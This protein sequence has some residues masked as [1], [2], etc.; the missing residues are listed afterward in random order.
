MK[1]SSH[2]VVPF[3]EFSCAVCGAQLDPTH[4]E[5][6]PE[7]TRCAFCGAVQPV[8]GP[9]NLMLLPRDDGDDDLESLRSARAARG[10]TLEQAAHFT[11]IRLTYLR[12][13]ES[14]DISSFEPYPGQVYA[15]FFVREYAEHLGVDPEPILRRFD[16]EAVPAVQ[17]MPTPIAQ[18]TVR[19]RRWVIGAL[20]VLAALLGADARLR[21]G[22]EPPVIAR[23]AAG[24]GAH[25]TPLRG[26]TGTHHGVPVPPEGLQV[27]IHTT[28]PCWIH[29]TVDGKSALEETVP[30]GK[31]VRFR[32]SHE[33]DLRLGN[34]GGVRIGVNGRPV[35]T[36]APGQVLDVSFVRQG[37]RIVRV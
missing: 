11:N 31:T 29:A 15:R 16:Q 19:R 18:R 36:G 37:D 27:V 32:A 10:E 5:S 13:L 26:Q 7:G 12:H 28:V 6:D 20:V 24:E 14:G 3:P 2:A 33:I 30:A 1:A 8:A 25:A 23:A 35:R 34:A 17:P 4:L 22:S 21:L 9:P